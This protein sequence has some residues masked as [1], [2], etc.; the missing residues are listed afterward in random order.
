MLVS[1]EVF[2]FFL[3]KRFKRVQFNFHLKGDFNWRV[4]EG[5]GG[6]GKKE[7]RELVSPSFTTYINQLDVITLLQVVQDS[8]VVEIGQIGHVFNFFEFGRIDL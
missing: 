5:Q 8:T 3:K 2:F 7:N 6:K 4:I 1:F